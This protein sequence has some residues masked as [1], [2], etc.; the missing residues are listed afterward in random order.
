ML[1]TF[2]YYQEGVAGLK[3]AFAVGYYVSAVAAYHD[4]EAAFGQR[5][6]AEG[7][8]FREVPGCEHKGAE[9]GGMFFRQLYAEVR[10]VFGV[11]VDK[12]KESG[13]LITPVPCITSDSSVTKNTM[14]NICD[15]PGTS[16]TTG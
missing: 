11:V 7:I 9:R 13:R 12:A 8:A 1:V 16:A 14:L 15:A 2:L 10:L 3:A 5:D 4:Y 6:A